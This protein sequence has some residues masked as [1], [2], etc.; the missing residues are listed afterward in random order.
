MH[1][2]GQTSPAL[3]NLGTLQPRPDEMLIHRLLRAWDRFVFNQPVD[4]IVAA[5]FRSLDVAYQAASVP[6]T[7]SVFE[8]GTRVV[9]WVSALE[10]LAHARSSKA[11]RK[12][13]L[14]LLGAFQWQDR[15]LASDQAGGQRNRSNSRVSRLMMGLAWVVGCLAVSAVVC[16][17][18]TNYSIRLATTGAILR[19][20]RMTPANASGVID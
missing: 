5:I 13:V 3:P 10:I 14:D 2:V 15:R 17:I 4:P 18:D 20:S 8:Y 7:T 6:L 16:V 12:T 19:R 9:L 11:S 1:F